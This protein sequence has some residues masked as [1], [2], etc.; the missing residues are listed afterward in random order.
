MRPESARFIHLGINII[1]IPGALMSAQT[2]LRFQQAAIAEGL[3]YQ[4]VQTAPD[5]VTLARTS[6][7]HLEISAI[8][9]N[10]QFLQ[11]LVVAPE[12]KYALTSFAA[13]VVAAT[14]A[15]SRVWSVESRQIIS[16][17]A[18][19]REL[20]E[21]SATHA[22]QEL[23]E[24][25]LGQTNEGL[26][27][28]GRPVLGGGLRLVLAPLPNEAN[29]VQIEV[30]IESFLQD[31]SKMFVETQFRWTNPLEAGAPYDPK[32]YLDEM[33][34]FITTKIREFMTG[35]TTSD[36]AK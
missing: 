3:E 31:A 16:V 18:A 29:P 10:P 2:A 21:I 28:F 30:K 34:A 6:G 33:Y 24:S 5:R 19:I 7:S 27:T 1:T 8:T 23:W 35:V 12:P 22:F 17:D 4:D 13:D 26:A 15:F 32:Q 14:A 20:Y 9:P 36:N 25:R 11:L